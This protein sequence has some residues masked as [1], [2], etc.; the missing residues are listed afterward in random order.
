MDQRV[1]GRQ[2]FPCISQYLSLKHSK[3]LFSL[4]ALKKEGSED[5]PKVRLSAVSCKSLGENF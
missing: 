5:V 2:A 1:Q 3:D 4:T